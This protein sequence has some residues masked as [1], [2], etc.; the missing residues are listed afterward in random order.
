[1]HRNVFKY[2]LFFP[3]LLFFTMIIHAQSFTTKTYTTADGLSD[4]C[5]FCVY[6]D[7]YGYLWIGT[8][9]GLNRFDGKRFRNFGL[10][11]GLPSL[12]VDRIYEDIEHRLWIGTRRGIAE[13]KGDSCYSY[14]LDD[15]QEIRFVSGFMEPGNGRLWAT[16][17]RGIYELKDNS[18]AK[19][20]LSPGK[21]NHGVGK[22]IKTTKGLYINYDNNTVV[23]QKPDG[24]YEVILSIAT[25][26]PYFNSLY[27]KN[28]TV[29]IST[30]SGLRY[31]DG[32][33]WISRFA[34]TL[35]RKY[36]FSSF[37][38]RNDR[39]WF[40]TREDGVLAIMPGGNNIDYLHIPLSFNLVSNFYED[41]E[42][43]IW[44]AG[45]RGL[46]K[47]SPSPYQNVS[48][49]G[50]QKLSTIRNC[51][52]MP[53]GNMALS[54][55]D[56]T[57]FFVKPPISPKSSAEVI[58]TFH[59]THPNDF[60]DY[61]TFDEKKRIWFTTREGELYRS[62]EHSLTNLTSIIPYKINALSGLVYNKKSREL[63][64]CAD[65]VFLA[66][67]EGRLD[68][69]FSQNK[70]QFISMPYLVYSN[71]SDGSL[72][73]QT[74]G[75]G[76]Y[77][78][79]ANGEIDSIGKSLNLLF[80]FQIN[81]KDADKETVVWSA[82]RGK[83][84]SKYRWKSSEKPELL[85][86]ITDK[87]GLTDN[88]ILNFFLD[89]EEKLWIATSKGVS[90][91]QKQNKWTHRD[92]EFTESGSESPLSFAKFCEDGDGNIWMTLQDKLVVFDGKKIDMTPLRTETIIE[93]VSLFDRP[94]DW[95]LLTDSVYSYRK[96]PVNPTLKY[97]QNT[98]SIAFNG[99]LLNNTSPV[100]YSYRLLP[101]DTGWSNPT[102][103]E[104]VTFYQLVPGAYRFQVRS[105]IRGVDWS[106][107]A[108][109]S[110]TIKKPLWET[111]WFRIAIILIASAI[112]VLI[113]RY[114]LNQLKEK[115]LMQNQI[116]ELEMKALKAQMNP[117]FIHNALNSIQSLI[118]NNRST[119]A[120]HYISKFA[121]L[122]RQV[123]ENADKNLIS[124]DKELYSLK[125]YV[126]L[127]K[128]RMSMDI[129]YSEHM[130]EN[131]IAS[132]I[133]IPP[134]ILQPFVENALWHGLSNKEGNKKI[135]LAIK[136]K[137]GWIICEIT[138]NGIGRKKAGETGRPFPEGSL[139][140]AVNI[141]T[142]R[143]AD[144]NQTPGTKP[145]SFVDLEDNNEAAG[146]TV[147]IRIR[148]RYGDR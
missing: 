76:V 15:H 79:K 140:K 119:E 35:R 67:N 143:L 9:N 73:V 12:S 101:S 142:Q 87:D 81:G 80:S 113:F 19:I 26:R 69:L 95:T 109:F 138:D 3:A 136:E 147:I 33:N 111:W 78:V 132:E 97:N 122:L 112:I 27:A 38:D 41:R 110:F 148:A 37:C 86:V 71:E 128:L 90:V 17:D 5:I 25:N 23:H 146:T 141:T 84:I 60:I 51:I 31:W 22:I 99:L 47:V 130:D 77:L 126:D 29:F 54:C 55:E 8:Q 18:W 127:E 75:N 115:N 6:Q 91:M 139:S 20:S 1:L 92:F 145:V 56:G 88:L 46:V 63:F 121:K 40:G 117:H 104:I 107:P 32:S 13:L 64:V 116:R 70:K 124:L 129:D 133:R 57:L 43:N 24:N 98:L 100:E 10:K 16:T 30:Y 21:D 96:L 93:Q 45:F 114:R 135:T 53:S 44:V 61:Y 131:I 123:L 89:K 2:G 49:N 11:N 14:P 50:P 134:L 62:D 105:H 36:I 83:D 118:I 120:S 82:N 65:S 34:D 94:T 66:G 137:E 85:E 7:S 48:F 144:F 108:L 74:I 39:F 72:L 103:S 52:A 59:L 106:E 68:T 4:N 125:L 102:V 28:D 58:S 42:G